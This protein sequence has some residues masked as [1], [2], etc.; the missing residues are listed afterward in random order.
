M[1]VGS[2]VFAFAE[3]MIRTTAGLTFA[4]TSMMADDSSI[5]TCCGELV[6]W[7]AGSVVAAAGWSRAPAARR[8]RYVPPEARMA[9]MIAAARI[10]AEQAPAAGLPGRG[11]AGHRRRRGGRRLEPR[12]R[13]GLGRGLPGDAVA[14]DSL[15]LGRECRGGRG[16]RGRVRLRRG[17]GGLRRSGPDRAGRGFGAGRAG[18]GRFGRGRQRRRLGCDVGDLRFGSRSGGR[19]A[20]R[21]RRGRAGAG[22]PRAAGSSRRGLVRIGVRLGRSFGH[23]SM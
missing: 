23:E 22:L 20:G 1:A 21:V 7:P 5:R 17:L 16:R 10:G 14:V 4:A 18:R 9:A 6:V 15:R 13:G 8:V 3:L 12:L 2:W 19:D 11:R